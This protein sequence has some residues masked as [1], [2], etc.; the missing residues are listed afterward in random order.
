[1]KKLNHSKTNRFESQTIVT[2]KKNN[3][4]FYITP[5]YAVNTLLKR[6]KFEGDI[7][8]PSCG[9]GSISNAL[10][11]HKYIVYSYDINSHKIGYGLQKDFLL[12]TKSIDNIITN[13]PYNRTLDFILHGLKLYNNKMAFLIRLAFVESQK[14]YKL[15]FEHHKPARIYIFSKRINYLPTGN[16]FGGGLITAWFVWDKEAKNKDTIIRWINDEEEN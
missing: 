16:T 11:Q 5:P 6:E 2:G 4:D 9:N 15:I 10:K 12:R 7:L 13:P 3:A 1:M 14:R 8:E